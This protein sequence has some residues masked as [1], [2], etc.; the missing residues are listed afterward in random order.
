M[1]LSVV[2]FVVGTASLGA[3]IA[4]ARL[5]A[6]WFGA[7]T[8]VWA[9]TIAVVLVALSAGY[10]LGGRLADRD[11]TIGGLSRIVL[12]AAVLLAIVPFVSG[13]FLRASVDAFDELSV[14]V[15]AGSLLGVGVLVAVPLLLLGTV[16]P[17]AVRLRMQHVEDAGRTAGRLYSISTVGSLVGTFAAALLLIP[18]VGTRRTFLVFALLLALVAIPGLVRHRLPALLVPLVVLGLIALPP[19]TTKAGTAGDRVEWEKETDYQ[20]ARVLQADDGTRTLELNE[21][22]AVHSLYRPGS[23]LT[24]GYWDDQLALLWAGGR[25]PRSVAILGSAAGTTARAVGHYSPGTRVDAVEIDPDVTEVGR[26]LF[27]MD[28]PHLHTYAADARPWLEQH[29]QRQ[30]A[31]VIDAYRQPYIPFYLTT[32]EF[33]SLVRSRL[34]PGGVAIVNVGHPEGSTQLQKALAATMRSVFGP[35]AVLRDDGEPTNTMLVATTSR[36]S[37]SASLRG[38]GADLPP[39]LDT[40]MDQVASRLRPALR[41]GPVWTDDKAPVE[42]LVD[43]SLADVATGKYGR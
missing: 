31:I 41:G 18:F 8:I 13:P 15:F 27:D 12:A 26:R 3:E 32:R 14:G 19:G 7:S 9:N 16:S 29:R 34:A 6:P 43:L 36:T 35:E 24:D 2:V 20:Y 21:G 38:A 11:P 33:F 1:P 42:W 30:D 22:Q 28:G 23:Y 10:A 5:L 37:A 25:T 39:E 40:V 4:A 17:Y